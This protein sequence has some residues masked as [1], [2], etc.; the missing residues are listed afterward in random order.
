[1]AELTS[2][3]DRTGQRDGAGQDSAGLDRTGHTHRT[4][5]VGQGRCVYRNRNRSR[6]SNKIKTVTGQT[7]QTDSDCEVG[8]K[9]GLTLNSH[10]EGQRDTPVTDAERLCAGY[11]EVDGI[12]VH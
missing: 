12:P 1:M 6:S 4:A 8:P 7:R 5:I 2:R 10:A 3:R 9:T 11:P